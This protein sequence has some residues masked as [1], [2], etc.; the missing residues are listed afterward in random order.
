MRCC[1]GGAAKL[2]PDNWLTSHRRH[3]ISE[4]RAPRIHLQLPLPEF[5]EIANSREQLQNN[6][7]AHRH[8]LLGKITAL[9]TFTS[10]YNTERC[11]DIM[12]FV[13]SQRLHHNDSGAVLRKWQFL[14]NAAL[15][16]MSS[17]KPTTQ[18]VLRVACS[19]CG[20]SPRQWYL[21]KFMLRKRSGFKRTPVWIDKI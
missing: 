7:D 3:W 8:H 20:L 16:Q 12:S 11:Y 21:E 1:Y 6:S 17:C 5:S 4:K 10:T 14:H 13:G 15:M 9:H 19:E 2:L 18:P